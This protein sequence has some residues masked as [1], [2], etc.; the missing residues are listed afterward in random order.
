MHIPTPIKSPQLL[1]YSIRRQT[2]SKCTYF[3]LSENLCVLQAGFIFRRRRHVHTFTYQRSFVSNRM[4][5]SL[6][7]VD[8][9]ILS[10]IREAL[11]LTEW[12]YL[13]TASTCTYFH[14]SENLSVLQAGFIFRRFRHVHTFTYH[15][16]AV[17]LTCKLIYLT[18]FFPTLRRCTDIHT[19]IF[20]LKEGI[21]SKGRSKITTP[22]LLV[23]PCLEDLV[24]DN[25]N[26]HCQKYPDS[27]PRI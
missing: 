10:P 16:L 22:T 13:Q 9:Y 18:R 5:L 21:S 20:Y 4:V 2:A 14:L 1:S 25:Y 7:G 19:H 15:R 12:F 23:Q 6:D 17:Y 26:I 8:L 3:H 24:F 27:L 11:C